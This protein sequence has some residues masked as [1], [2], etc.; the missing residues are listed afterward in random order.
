MAPPHLATR[1]KT[2]LKWWVIKMF[3][4]SMRLV[5][6]KKSIRRRRS[7]SRKRMMSSLSVISTMTALS[8][9]SIAHRSL[10]WTTLRSKSAL[11]DAPKRSSRRNFRRKWWLSIR[12]VQDSTPAGNRRTRLT[13]RL[14][15]TSRH[16]SRIRWP[17]LITVITQ[18]AYSCHH[19]MASKSRRCQLRRAYSSAEASTRSYR[20]I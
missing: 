2:S 7:R 14:S 16:C 5:P 9:R 18:A 6:R 20:V 13:I 10:K 8:W 4:V 19:L 3:Y 12:F 17:S 11:L 1:E 15:L